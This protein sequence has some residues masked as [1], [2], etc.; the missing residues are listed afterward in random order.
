[1]APTNRKYPTRAWRTRL[2]CRKQNQKS[3]APNLILALTRSGITIVRRPPAQ[4]EKLMA[5]PRPHGVWKDFHDSCLVCLSARACVCVCTR[6][7][8]MCCGVCARGCAC[9]FAY[10]HVCMRVHRRV[11]V[12]VCVR[13]RVRG[14][15]H[16]CVDKLLLSSV[17]PHLVMSCCG[18]ERPSGGSVCHAWGAVVGVTHRLCCS[19]CHAWGAVPS[20]VLTARQC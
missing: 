3:G 18:K 20:G 10:A 6:T 12:C 16:A 9:T 2:G 5:F 13:V 19:W 14:Y 7:C 1:M 15:L 4:G 8:V 17:C 11:C